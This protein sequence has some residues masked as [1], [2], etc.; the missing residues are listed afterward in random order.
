[1]E[2]GPG[3]VSNQPYIVIETQHGDVLPW[4][5]SQADVLAEDWT[6]LK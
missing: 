4:L 2:P 3:E 5:A 1:V 6:V